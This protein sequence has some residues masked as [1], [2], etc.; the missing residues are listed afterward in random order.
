MIAKNPKLALAVLLTLI[1]LPQIGCLRTRGMMREDRAFDV[2]PSSGRSG[3]SDLVDEL[4]AEISRL[5]GR[6]EEL[7]RARAENPVQSADPAKSNEVQDRLKAL[8]ERVTDLDRAQRALIELQKGRRTSLPPETAPAPGEA[9]ATGDAA[10]RGSLEKGRSLFQAGR[11]DDA[12]TELSVFLEKNP[13]A[14]AASIEEASELLGE[15]QF[16]MKQYQT[17][18][19]SFS[20]LTNSRRA[21]GALLRI[22]QSFEALGLQDDARNFY[23]ELQN[24]YPKSAEAKKARSGQGKKK[25]KG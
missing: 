3:Q 18:I 22:A 11:F 24:R 2:D 7:E 4:R 14:K 8:E 10:P 5:S 1:T 13:K 19:T 17:A 12:A 25:G 16:V 23:Q 21:P 6:I 15:S 9:P 20:R